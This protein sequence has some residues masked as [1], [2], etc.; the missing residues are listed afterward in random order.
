[1]CWRRLLWIS[2]R[3]ASATEPQ[4]HQLQKE[5]QMQQQQ[6]QLNCLWLCNASDDHN[7]H[8]KN[9][10]K[11]IM[12]D[13]K[14]STTEPQQHQ[15][16][17]QPQLQQQSMIMTIMTRTIGNDH[18]NHDK[19]NRK[20]IIIDRKVSTREPQQHQLQKQ[21]QLQQQVMI[22]TIMTRTIGNDHDNHDKNSR[23]TIIT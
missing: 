7:N 15:L 22:T 2:N 17:K 4:Q 23:K 3:K 16:Q 6:K 13:R 1:M 18:D 5:L 11:T 20:T 8:D 19:N 14:V 21:P 9:N 12:I 10:R